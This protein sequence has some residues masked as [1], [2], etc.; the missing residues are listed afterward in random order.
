M[1]EGGFDREQAVCVCC[2]REKE[3]V[4]GREK[5]SERESVLCEGVCFRPLFTL[6]IYRVLFVSRKTRLPTCLSLGAVLDCLNS[7]RWP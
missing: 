4:C 6:G 5:D 1:R 2:K 3:R 7:P